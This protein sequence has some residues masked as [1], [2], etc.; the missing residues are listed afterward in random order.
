MSRLALDGTDVLGDGDDGAGL[1]RATAGSTAEHVIVAN[2]VSIV[3]HFLL[4]SIA[5]TL[6]LSID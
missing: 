5:A 2:K 3:S 4:Q 1:T 6:L